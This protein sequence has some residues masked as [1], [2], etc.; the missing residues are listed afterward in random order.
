MVRKSFKFVVLPFILCEGPYIFTKVM[1][2]LVKYWRSQVLCLVVYLGDGLGVCGTKDTW[3][4]DHLC[5]YIKIS[6][7]R[8]SWVP[9][10]DKHMWIPVQLL[11]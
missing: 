2:P 7:A 4:I 8:C 1:R 3:A 11:R 10:K 9:N 5:W 6:F